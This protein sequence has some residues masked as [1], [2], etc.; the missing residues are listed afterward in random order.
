MDDDDENK[1]AA[2]VSHALPHQ[3]VPVCY[4]EGQFKESGGHARAQPERPI[5]SV[6]ACSSTMPVSLQ[7]V[8]AD[9]L[10]KRTASVFARKTNKKLTATLSQRLAR[11]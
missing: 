2:H 1:D 8:T 6:N 9:G 5:P 10:Q 4:S 3:N 7:L 11:L